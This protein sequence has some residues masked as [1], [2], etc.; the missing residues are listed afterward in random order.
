[1]WALGDPNHGQAGHAFSGT[2]QL[3]AI[4]VADRAIRRP[5]TVHGSIVPADGQLWTLGDDGTITHHDAATGAAGPS[6]RSDLESPDDVVTATAFVADH[7]LWTA[8]GTAIVAR[9]PVSLA[10]VVSIATPRCHQLVHG[11]QHVLCATATNASTVSIIDVDLATGEEVLR[12]SVPSYQQYGSH[13]GMTTYV[14]EIGAARSGYWYAEEL[15]A[16]DST[17]APGATSVHLFHVER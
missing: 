6:L 2:T 1:V 17:D 3:V 14:P 12:Q 15:P 9:D 13:V 11:P 8:E 4:D 16:P 5:L 7:R 10:T